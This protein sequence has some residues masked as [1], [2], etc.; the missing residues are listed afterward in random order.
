M[1][2]TFTLDVIPETGKVF[3]GDLKRQLRVAREMF[4]S[5]LRE[6][7]LVLVNDRTMCD[8]HRRY[9]ND[10]T[11]TDV[12]TF[13]IDL[14]RSGRATA[15][16]VYVCVPEA[17]RMSKEHGTRAADE[18]LL[19]AL[20][21]MLHLAGFDDRT[22]PEFERMHRTE[23]RILTRLGVGPVFRP[24]A[25]FDGSPPRRQR[26]DRAPRLAAAS[27]RR[28]AGKSPKRRVDAAAKR[29]RRD[30]ARR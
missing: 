14:D 1:T 16:E 2:S 26:H 25:T 22:Q 5:P 27:T 9:M 12:L 17:R 23:D 10:P 7:S 8:L 24:R 19:Y 18:V 3:A 30:G 20:H 29:S 11:T 15:G 21:G 4:T 28:S 13:P 6:M